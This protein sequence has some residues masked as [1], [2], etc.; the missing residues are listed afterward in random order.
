[1]NTTDQQLDNAESHEDVAL[2]SERVNNDIEQQRSPVLT[3]KVNQWN[4]FLRI[5]G[6]FWLRAIVVLVHGCFVALSVMT[7]FFDDWSNDSEGTVW[8][9]G[10]DESVFQHLKMMLWPWLLLLFPMDFLARVYLLPKGGPRE[11][12]TWYCR[13]IAASSW[14]SLCLAS[15][16]AMLSAMLFITVVYAILY[17]AGSKSLVVDI[18]LFLAAI[19]GGA[20]LRIFWLKREA[21]LAW[22]AFA[23]LLGGTI[24]FFTYFSY[25]DDLYVG[26][27]FNPDPYNNTS[28]EE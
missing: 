22:T 7:H 21:A 3:A 16:I 10:T 18:I 25:S 19:I 13:C 15:T 17:Y 26:Y 2:D 8:V 6:S 20:I 24:W 12:R 9:A 27:L 14:L 5:P 28:E 23:Y 4:F 1:M 11:G